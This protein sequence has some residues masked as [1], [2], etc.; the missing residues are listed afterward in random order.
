MI[1]VG[2]TMIHLGGYHNLGVELSS[3]LPISLICEN[4][5]VVFTSHHIIFF[6][7]AD[8]FFCLVKCKM[9][10]QYITKLIKC[11]LKH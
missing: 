8:S 5:A 9:T 3:V 11:R 6:I 7:W 2:D 10:G 1:H 4:Q